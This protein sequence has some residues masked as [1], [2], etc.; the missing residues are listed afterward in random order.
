MPTPTSA[1]G[2]STYY[3]K[4]YNRTIH[5]F[6]MKQMAN[7]YTYSKIVGVTAFAMVLEIQTSFGF[8]DE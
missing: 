1:A 8:N 3:E 2:K 5:C 6:N 4:L 7:N